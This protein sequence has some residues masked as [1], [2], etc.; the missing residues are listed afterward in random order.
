MGFRK[1]GLL[2]ALI[3][4]ST[5]VS[6]YYL[7]QHVRHLPI[8]APIDPPAKPKPAA[9]SFYVETVVPGSGPILEEY[10]L[11]TF[12]IKAQNLD[13]EVIIDTGSTPIRQIIVSTIDGFRAG[14][15][16]MQV[17]ERRIVH[18]DPK[19]ESK[20]FNV[21]NKSSMIVYDVELVS[22]DKRL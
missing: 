20:S 3:A 4:F 10:D 19:I 18:V 6:S 14:V 13:N 21:K 17:G 8:P 2:K 5:L 11:A 9:A 15:L 22:L 16:G 7:I 1:D 12:N